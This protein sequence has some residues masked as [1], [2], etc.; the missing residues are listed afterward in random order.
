MFLYVFS[1]NPILI[2]CSFDEIAFFKYTMSFFLV[3]LSYNFH[4]YL[5]SVVFYIC[6][7]KVIGPLC[8]I[9][10]FLVCI[11]ISVKAVRN[12]DQEQR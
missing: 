1:F 5:C 7:R 8:F 2:L 10:S 3:C 12:L 9:F 6:K 11:Y 4:S